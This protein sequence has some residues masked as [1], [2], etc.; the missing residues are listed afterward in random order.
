M[1]DYLTG[2]FSISYLRLH[3]LYHVCL[4]D[5]RVCKHDPLGRLLL[6]LVRLAAQSQHC[7]EGE[8]KKKKPRCYYFVGFIILSSW[9]G[10]LKPF[11]PRI[12]L[13]YDRAKGQSIYCCCL[14]LSSC[15]STLVCTRPDLA[16]RLYTTLLFHNFAHTNPVREEDFLIPTHW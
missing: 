15:T 14:L 13:G 6:L 7:E 3:F 2:S 5:H 4:F 1:W 8:E 9:L 10:F 16:D 12:L 11:L